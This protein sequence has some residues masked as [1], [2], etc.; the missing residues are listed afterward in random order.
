MDYTKNI[1]DVITKFFWR[2]YPFHS[3]EEKEKNL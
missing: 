3:D 1:C 2:F